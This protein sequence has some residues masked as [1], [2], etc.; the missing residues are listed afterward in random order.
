MHPVQLRVK[1]FQ[2]QEFDHYIESFA[3]L[4]IMVRYIPPL[5]LG[6]NQKNSDW[7]RDENLKGISK[8]ED[9]S[10]KYNTNNIK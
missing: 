8:Q 6:T 2:I 9:K 5:V 3:Y 7:V 4:R 1:T 10:K